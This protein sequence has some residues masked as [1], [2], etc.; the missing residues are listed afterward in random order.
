M[1]DKLANDKKS[2]VENVKDRSLEGSDFIM[3]EKVL[4]RK[5][6]GQK[7]KKVRKAKGKRLK[8][9]GI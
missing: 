6:K 4:D 8:V 9:G 3:S 2:A 5:A 1:T 7:D